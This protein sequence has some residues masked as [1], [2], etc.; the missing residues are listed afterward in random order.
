MN[1]RDALKGIER[2]LKLMDEGLAM[3]ESYD[4]YWGDIGQN[5]REIDKTTKFT[6]RLRETLVLLEE[7]KVQDVK[8]IFGLK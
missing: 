5:F 4:R 3:V 6:D 1:R 7:N 2:G 8:S